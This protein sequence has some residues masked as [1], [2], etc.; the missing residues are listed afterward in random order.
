MNLGKRSIFLALAALV[1]ALA[2]PLPGAER[3]AAGSPATPKS[4]PAK[5]K[6]AA[7]P[8]RAIPLEPVKPVKPTKPASL[9]RDPYLGA[10]VVDAADGRVLF[11]ERAD[12][13]GY[14]ASVLK[15]MLLLTA[16]EQIDAGK[17]SLEDEVKVSASAV[18]KEGADLQLKE[19]E[20][21][22]V[23]DML[24][25]VMIHSA[26]DAAVA[27]AEK[28]GGS[29]AG[30]L[31]ISNRRAQELGMTNSRFVSANGLMISSGRFKG[32]CSRATLV[33]DGGNSVLHANLALDLMDGMDLDGLRGVLAHHA[34]KVAV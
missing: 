6:P 24:Y 1:M 25:A 5:P 9:A 19:G 26:N 21:F 33:I 31:E 2:A 22:K 10:I 11:E 18:T 29:L 28:L 17:L 7:K 13:K 14:P 32:L 23:E 20:V 16:M 34:N 3:K 4:T 27:L 8:P 15:L 12:E 30:Y